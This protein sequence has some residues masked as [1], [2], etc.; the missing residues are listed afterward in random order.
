[1]W[2][3]KNT[4]SF[5]D[6]RTKLIAWLSLTI[7]MFLFE[8]YMQYICLILLF[9][10]LLYIFY[11]PSEI[12]S[13]YRSWKLLL[14]I[15]TINLIANL[16]FENGKVL[17]TLSIF[18]FTDTDIQIFM[19]I[20]LL[21]FFSKCVLIK[22][23]AK[24]LGIA[25]GKIIHTLSWHK[26]SSTAIP[27]ITIIILSFVDKFRQVMQEINKAY[28]LRTKGISHKELV[29]KIRA[30]AMLLVPLLMISMKKTEQVSTALLAKGYHRGSQV[31]DYLK[32]NYGKN[33][34]IAYIILGLFI[35]FVM[36]L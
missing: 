7:I 18:T 3:G 10:L 19:R 28:L 25:I 30:R 16:L 17:Y 14:L 12:K 11:K 24:E 13:I 20:F 2:M 29:Q 4:L 9:F 32:I 6:G 8:N 21:L 27:L 34:Y 35:F 22:T 33:D 26:I 23:E 36:S 1:M 31:V 5:L 15:P